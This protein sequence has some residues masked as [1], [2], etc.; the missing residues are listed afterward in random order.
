MGTIGYFILFAIVFIMGKFIYD[1]YLTNNTKKKWENHKENEKNNKISVGDIKS[2][3]DELQLKQSREYL[4][5][6]FNCR[7][8]NLEYKILND[9]ENEM[10]TEQQALDTI[11]MLEEGIQKEVDNLGFK[12]ENTSSYLLLQF[13]EKYIHKINNEFVEE[14]DYFF[15]S[16]TNRRK[17]LKKNYYIFRY[18]LKYIAEEE[19]YITQEVLGTSPEEI[20]GQVTNRY[21]TA[22]LLK[23]TNLFIDHYPEISDYDIINL[24]SSPSGIRASIAYECFKDAL[25]KLKEFLVYTDESLSESYEK[26][27]RYFSRKL[28]KNY[29]AIKEL[30]KTYKDNENLDFNYQLK[31]LKKEYKLSINK[32][33]PKV[34]L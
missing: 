9:F 17:I 16:K 5:Q 2:N 27:Q 33:F 28:I 29:R 21:R 25:K 15:S 26:N 4:A 31:V 7:V 3:I 10:T 30:K 23:L 11:E 18:S 1:S 24:N 12:R 22:E 19:K 6:Q 20:I 8:N 32:W 14:E 34:K 13:A